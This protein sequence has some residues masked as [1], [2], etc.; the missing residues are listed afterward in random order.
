MY[1]ACFFFFFVEGLSYSFRERQASRGA[2][3]EPNLAQDIFVFSFSARENGLCQSKA[4]G[5][6]HIEILSATVHILLLGNVYIIRPLWRDPSNRTVYRLPLRL[7]KG[8][9]RFTGL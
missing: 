3:R 5:H 7:S 9:K 8:F 6:P 2:C 1:N 4:H